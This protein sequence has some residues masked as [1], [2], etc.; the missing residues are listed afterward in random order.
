MKKRN[1]LLVISIAFMLT[2]LAVIFSS[3]STTKTG[4]AATKNMVGYK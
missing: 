3:C 4:C 2:A 1:L